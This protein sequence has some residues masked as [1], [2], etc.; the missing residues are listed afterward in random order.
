[1]TS[2]LGV[3][4]ARMASVRF[5]GKVLAPLGGKPMVQRVW[6]RAL[7]SPAL[8]RLVI[9]TDDVQ[10]L[11]AAE[12]FGAEVMLTRPEH[13][14]GTDRVAE[15]AARST[16]PI[17]VNIQGDEPF[18]EPDAI[19]ALVERII[20]TGAPIATCA[21][22]LD[23]KDADD[24][25]T[26]KVVCTAAGDALY[27][28]RSRIPYPR[29]EPGPLRKHF[30]I[31]AFTREALRTVAALPPSAL[32]RA[33]G[34]EQLRWLEAGYRIAVAFTV[35]RGIAIDTPADLAA[36]ERLLAAQGAAK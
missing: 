28:S 32:E 23:E 30:G 25:N 12:S 33:E 19:T 9:A 34:L 26:V 6:E 27:F 24:P 21:G 18:I 11:T 36:A 4:P 10:V 22:V 31:Y 35:Y 14:S 16:E 13:P 5:P 8:S 20:E 29:H 7:S 17:I 1:M 2:A 15:V 3:I